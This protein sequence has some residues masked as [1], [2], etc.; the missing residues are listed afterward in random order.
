MTPNSKS[1]R[2]N[3]SCNQRCRICMCFIRP[4]PRRATTNRAADESLRN[5]SETLIPISPK[6]C[7]T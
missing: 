6:R 7:T 5:L 4:G 2:R 3:P 1:P